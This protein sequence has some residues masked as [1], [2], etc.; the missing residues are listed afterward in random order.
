[1]KQSRNFIQPELCLPARPR[2]V[3][4]ELGRVQGAYNNV[5]FLPGGNA[6]RFGSHAQPPDCDRLNSLRGGHRDV[7]RGKRLRTS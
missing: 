1:M 7:A 4:Y 5:V 2:R 3:R 6:T